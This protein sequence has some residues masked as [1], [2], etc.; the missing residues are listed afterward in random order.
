[1]NGHR[2][3]LGLS[4]V[5]AGSPKRKKVGICPTFFQKGEIMRETKMAFMMI[6]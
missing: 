2:E 6:S 5:I 3:A 4:G 1:M